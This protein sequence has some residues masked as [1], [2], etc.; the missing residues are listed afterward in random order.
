MFSGFDDTSSLL[1]RQSGSDSV[2]GKCWGGIGQ[3]ECFPADRCQGLLYVNQCTDSSNH[4]CC[5][6]RECTVPQGTGWCKDNSNQTC[7][8]GIFVSGTGPP[9]PCPGGNSILCCVKYADMNNGT[10][11]STSTGGP[12]SSTAATSTP[13]QHDRSSTGLAPSQIG[14]IV[15]GVV[16]FVVVV[17]ALAAGWFL[18]RRRRRG[19]GT[20]SEQLHDGEGESGGSAVAT[21]GEK[22]EDVGGG[23]DKGGDP[24]LLDGHMRQEMDAQGRAALHEMDTNA[25]D[26]DAKGVVH[27]GGVAEL[28]AEMRLAELP[29]RR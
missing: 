5:L 20:P 23:G 25:G 19:R 24:P 22:K 3:G 18:W 16:G 7:D 6:H 26:P 1:V 13:I 29:G 11:T 4:V 21:V 28:P 10:S 15:G 17:V 8:D 27:R 9:W 2:Y 14:G 12:P